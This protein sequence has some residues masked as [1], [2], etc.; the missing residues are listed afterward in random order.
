[1]RAVQQKRS[2]EWCKVPGNGSLLAAIVV[3]TLLHAGIAA[4]WFNRPLQTLQTVGEQVVSV[5]LIAMAAPAPEPVSQ[6]IQPLPLPPESESLRDDEMAEQHTVIKKKLP[7]KKPFEKKQSVQVPVTQTT[8]AVQTSSTVQTPV[9]AVSAPVTAARYDADYLN[10]PAPAY[11]AVSRRLGEE[12]RVLLR[13]NVSAEG[14]VLAVE[15]KKT[16]GF[17]RLDEAARNAAAKWRFVPAHQ[18]NTAI[19]SWV[20]VPIQFS[21]KK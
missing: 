17:E 20:E 16:S 7:A 5:D 11:P 8:P 3:S 4:W 10:N 18:G 21:L 19:T 13:V 2:G 14:K 15:L 12:G 6:S 1:M 9:N